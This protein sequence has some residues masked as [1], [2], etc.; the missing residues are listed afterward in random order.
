M[1]Y[2]IDGI[3]INQL[4]LRYLFHFSKYYEHKG[5][6]K[7][8]SKAKV[9]IPIDMWNHNYQTT[10]DNKDNKHLCKKIKPLPNLLKVCSLLKK[11]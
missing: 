9:Q 2:K 7:V 10:I 8:E 11:K 6:L 1:V 4:F 3:K 5:N